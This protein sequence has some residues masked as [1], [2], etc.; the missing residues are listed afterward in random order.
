MSTRSSRIAP[1]QRLAGWI[2]DPLTLLLGLVRWFERYS[3]LA[4]AR[5]FTVLSLATM[6]ALGIWLRF[7]ELGKKSLFADEVLTAQR[8]V[9][10]AFTTVFPDGLSHRSFTYMSSHYMVQWLG[11]TEISLRI[12]PAIAGCLGLVAMYLASRA[13]FGNR[14]ALVSTLLLTVSAAHINYSQ[15]ARFYAALALFSL[16]AT[17]GLVQA[18]RTNR[19]I[20]WFVFI[21]GTT[22]NL[23]NHLFAGFVL[24]AGALWA[25]V[26]LSIEFL[27]GSTAEE[28]R[29]SR[30]RW[31]WLI[32][33]GVAIILLFGPGLV[34]SFNSLDDALGS[35]KRPA[36]VSAPAND[37][38]DAGSTSDTLISDAQ[39]SI[40]DATAVKTD[41]DLTGAVS[42]VMS[43]FG[44]GT[45]RTLLLHASLC[46]AGIAAMAVRRRWA[47][48]LLLGLTGAIPFAALEVIDAQHFFVPKY[49]L[50][51]L[52]FYLMTMAYGA[53]SIG[54]LISRGARYLSKTDFVMIPAVG[55]LV[56]LVLVSALIVVAVPQVSI[57][58]REWRSADARGTAQFLL[59][60]AEQGD[61]IV[62][63]SRTRAAGYRFY[64][65]YLRGEGIS[66]NHG[67]VRVIKNMEDVQRETAR[68]KQLWIIAD[69][70]SLSF[71]DPQLYQW[72]VQNSFSIPFNNYSIYLKT[73]NAADLQ[74]DARIAM[75]EDA[76]KLSLGTY[77][78][79]I[80]TKLGDLLLTQ[81]SWQ[82][83]ISIYQS[84]DQARPQLSIAMLKIARTF[85]VR[86][87]WEDAVTA[88]QSL[89]NRWPNTASFSTLLGNAYV[90]IGQRDQALAAFRAAGQ[91]AGSK[92]VEL[93]ALGTAALNNGDITTAIESYRAAIAVE[94]DNVA[95][96][97]GAAEAYRKAGSTDEARAA[98]ERVAQ[99]P[100]P[101]SS[102]LF[103][104]AQIELA[105]GNYDRA[106]AFA[107]RALEASWISPLDVPAGPRHLQRRT[108]PANVVATTLLLGD[109][110]KARADTSGAE[111][112]YQEAANWAPYDPLPLIRI[113]LIYAGKQDFQTALSWYMRANS[114]APGS[115]DVHI[116]LARTYE[117]L[118]QFDDAVREYAT[119]LD[120]DPA[121]P[122]HRLALA[123]LL[124]KL[125]R[126]DEAEQHYRLL[127]RAAEATPSRP[128]F[129]GTAGSPSITA[130]FAVYAQAYAGL[131]DIV[132]DRAIRET[133]TL[134]EAFS[135]YQRGLA[136]NSNEPKL[137]AGLSK[138]YR[139]IRRPDLALSSYQ[140]VVELSPESSDTLTQLGEL[141]SLNGRLADS[142][143]AFRRALQ[144]SPDSY[145]T[146]IDLGTLLLQTGRLDDAK[147][148]FQQAATLD[149]NRGS[150]YKRIGDLLQQS[151]YRSDA[152]AL[153]MQAVQHDP[154]NAS[155]MVAIGDLYKAMGNIAEAQQWYTRANQVNTNSDRSQRR[156]DQLP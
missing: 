133:R 99:L 56:S 155:A 130:D 151:G 32:L 87:D 41:F 11:V 110:A 26:L 102:T 96:W 147:S 3:T 29:A 40:A 124:V 28:R 123:D 53:I 119:L 30:R 105:S 132:S 117:Q 145:Q 114:V 156:L 109:I 57:Y 106:N 95:A 46:L 62:M 58:Y 27:R 142:E 122:A 115:T 90:Q 5:A 36:V 45:E 8:Q 71:A 141:Y 2:P 94:P 64:H 76:W 78:N 111:S 100:N 118:K 50:F 7:H 14:T 88:Y 47:L 103:G 154:S 33:S 125:D 59:D 134:D 143:S 77:N 13:L 120:I 61:G 31:G 140:R 1:S 60:Y 24:A 42:D 83:A 80:P 9:D 6:I 16:L 23:Y 72:V 91:A 18:L 128:E 136:F 127:V 67:T 25:I 75:L 131:G 82:Q 10:Y 68:H 43:E 92:A 116:R 101:A 51:I 55:A 152:L 104:L 97:L 38:S 52:P 54:D 34:N 81:G 84:A 19:S 70:R 146:Y 98:V 4:L 150:A 79:A 149:P 108:V 49:V 137:Y 73:E 138:V 65:S 135:L 21:A 37:G 107:L 63:L 113:G 93:T 17:Y 15:Y 35:S 12:I 121:T 89:Q 69:S 66:T 22:L 44:F 126:P 39:A 86:K 153:Y 85:E 112:R 139:A 129:V 148:T 48:L 20:Y 144:V 74:P